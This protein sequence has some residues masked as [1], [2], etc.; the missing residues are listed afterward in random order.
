MANYDILGNISIVKFDRKAGKKE[1]KRFAEKLMRQ[2]PGV[3]IVLEKSGKFSGRLRTPETRF[4]LGEKTK[5]GLYKENDCSFRFNVDSCYFSSR[6]AS[7]RKEI[8]SY[9]KKGEK[10]LVMFGGVA[11]FAIVIAKHS[12]AEKVISIELGREC[13][14]YALDNIKRNKLI[15]KVE[16]IQGDVRKICPKL[17][18][19][20]KTEKDKFER[21]VMARPNLKDSFLD[22][23]LPLAKKNG[24]IHYYGFYEENKVNDLRTLI[25]DEAGK[26]GKR[27]KIIRIKKAGDI[28]VRKF[29]YRADIK[30]L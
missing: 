7:E 14:R 18:K 6:L 13:N 24:I 29:R 9:A 26:A 28:G 22:V 3:K 30:I 1:K 11:P 5:E 8:A 2:Y 25:M 21:I 23:A 27:I 16:I 15:D 12:S 19:K 4:V 17:R 10:V 20:M